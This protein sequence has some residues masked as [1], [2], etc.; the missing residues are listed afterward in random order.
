MSH[1]TGGAHIVLVGITAA[2]S[3]NPHYAIGVITLL[4]LH[5]RHPYATIDYMDM[6]ES[7]RLASNWTHVT[8]GI[9]CYDP[10]PTQV[11]VSPC[12]V[13]HWLY[14]VAPLA[15]FNACMSLKDSSCCGAAGGGFG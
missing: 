15:L 1:L 6:H 5:T 2:C 11:S 9:L 8:V 3:I 14:L 4:A 7:I 13:N 10:C 12:R